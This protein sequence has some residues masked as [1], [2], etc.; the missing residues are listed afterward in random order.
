MTRIPAG[1]SAVFFEGTADGSTDA[2][3]LR[4][5][6]HAWSG[7]ASLPAGFLIGA[8]GGSGVGLSTSGDAV[9]LFDSAGRRLAGVAFPGSTLG[10]T[11]DNAAGLNSLTL[12]LPV[13]SALSAAGVNGAF[14]A[15]DGIETGS[16]GSIGVGVTDD[17]GD[18]FT[19]PQELA[20]AGSPAGNTIGSNPLN[21][22]STPEVCDGADNDLNEGVDEGYAD[23][24]HDGV[25]DCVDADD[26]NDGIADVVDPAPLNAAN[27]TFSDLAAPLNG[28][29][30]GTILTRAGR[31]MSVV[32]ATPNPGVGVQIVVGPSG[33]D[34]AQVRL[35]GKAAIISLPDGTY[36][37]TDP[38]GTSTVTVVAGGPAQVSAVLNGL[39]VVLVVWEGGSVTY[40]ETLGPAGSLVGL[41]IGSVTGNVTLNGSVL[42]G[43]ITLVGP[44][45]TA[46]ACKK[47]E[48]EAFNFPG[49]FKN[50]G[51]CVSY[52]VTGRKN[53]PTGR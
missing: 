52:V 15:A 20:S 39:P 26:D 45:Q 25:T 43:S 27:Q 17:D 44:P 41:S 3:I 11:F 1:R 9:N 19:N 6:A 21:A 10:F 18:G 24:D 51:D 53:Q 8:Y 35:D 14:V 22:L 13:I 48:W 47:G 23:T 32:D 30:A 29:T 36:V 42:A 46:D 31:A 16:P 5:F 7:A 37:L 33:A 34:P 49:T 38:A 2:T 40:T 50:Q 12:P 4:N 28:R